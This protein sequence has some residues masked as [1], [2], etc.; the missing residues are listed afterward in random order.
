MHF[1]CTSIYASQSNIFNEMTSALNVFIVLHVL[2]YACT[3]LSLVLT[4]RKHTP[5]TK[6]VMLVRFDL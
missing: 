6:E 3:Y 5:K 1:I 4:Y 2:M